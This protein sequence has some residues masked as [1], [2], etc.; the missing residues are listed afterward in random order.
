MTDRTTHLTVGDKVCPNCC[1]LEVHEDNTRE[2]AWSGN[3]ASVP[4]EC[5][6]CGHTFCVQGT[7][8]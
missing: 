4:F 2:I 6:T 3:T 7:R 1:S 5:K 8:K